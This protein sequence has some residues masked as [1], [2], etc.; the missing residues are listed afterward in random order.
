MLSEKHKRDLYSSGL[1]DELINEFGYYTCDASEANRLL[2][3]QNINCECLVFPYPGIQNYFRLKPDG[4][5]LNGEGKIAKYLQKTNSESR[6]YIYKPIRESFATH[7]SDSLPILITEGE[8][9]TAKATLEF[10]VKEKL[11]LPIG[12]S[13]VWNWRTRKLIKTSDGSQV[14]V[15]DVIDDIKS[16]PIN[17][18]IIYISFDSDIETNEQVQNAENEL[19]RYFIGKGALRVCSVRI[20]PEENKLGLDDYIIKYGVEKFKDLILR[21]ESSS[22]IKYSIK[23]LRKLPK[24]TA[25][26]KLDVMTALIN[27]DQGASGSF[28]HDNNGSYHFNNRTRK[29][30]Q[31]EEDKYQMEIADEYG[32]YRDSSEFKGVYTKLEEHALFKGK[33]IKIRHFSHYNKNTGT[34]N[35]YN[36]DGAFYE[37]PK[38]LPSNKITIQKNGTNNIFF[39][40]REFD[41]IHYIPESVGFFEQYILDVCNFQHTE[42]TQLSP[43]QQRFLFTVWFYSLFF[44]DLMPTKPI[45]VMTGDY[46]SGKSTIQRLVGKLLFGASFNVSTIQGERDF[47]TSIINKYYLVYDNVDINEEWV[48]NAIASLSTGFKVEVRKLYSNMEM[49]QADPISYLAMNSMGQGLYK[50]PDVANR[51]LIFRTKRIQEFIP[52][53]ILEKDVLENRDAILSEIMDNLLKINMFIDDKFTYHGTFRMADFANLG[54]KIATALG[55]ENEFKIILEIVSNEQQSLPLEDNPLVDILDK[56]L[57]RRVEVKYISTGELYAECKSIAD[58][59]KLH[60]PFKSSAGFGKALQFAHENL[61][62]IYKVDVRRGH[63]NKMVWMITYK[64]SE[65]GRERNN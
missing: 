53:H 30:L 22:F 47:L 21:S 50:R 46:G 3:R 9:K 33:E 43:D 20:P 6:L 55:R 40:H 36:N 51:L 8:K 16:L 65:N 60:F 24:L 14:Y 15:P 42:Y 34:I 45:L 39:K 41:V 23:F 4:A 29:V 27:K 64:E 59:T 44:P 25:V 54:F 10:Y 12:I 58:T 18:R 26:E 49:F 17:N 52:P 57:N 13:G 48:R 35:I 62:Q 7:T 5:I 38:K 37:I 1:T 11:F 32:L 61:K 28:Y 31:L 56:W 19:A 2:E 63:A